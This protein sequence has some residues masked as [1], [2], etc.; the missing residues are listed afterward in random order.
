M[1][2]FVNPFNMVAI[3]AHKG[4]VLSIG[5]NQMNKTSPVYFNGRHDK[6]VHAE[7]AAL[8]PLKHHNLKNVDMYIFYFRKNG[9][10]GNS[11]P[12]AHCIKKFEE[13]G[14]NRV[15]YMEHGEVKTL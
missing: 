9:T 7:W 5:M 1:G 4:R 3:V 13:F 15:Y 12:C 10:M 14:I 8:R 11:K 2:N 6:G